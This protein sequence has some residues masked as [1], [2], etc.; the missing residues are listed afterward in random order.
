MCAYTA[1]N[2]ISL[3]TS[4][5][6]LVEETT[7]LSQVIDKLYHIKL[8]QVHLIMNWNRL[9]S[10]FVIGIDFI[11]RCKSNYHITKVHDFPLM[12]MKGTKQLPLILASIY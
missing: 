1:L 7:D 10:S 8:F 3:T 2:N 5:S 9:L 4:Q 12:L 6:V 11:G